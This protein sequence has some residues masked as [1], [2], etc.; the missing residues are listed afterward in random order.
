MNVEIADVIRLRELNHLLEE[1]VI[2]RTRLLM[3]AKQTW[4]ATFDAF[5]DP[6]A[7]VDQ[8]LRIV[9]T[10]L[11]HAKQ[12]GADVRKVNG[13]PCH[14]VLFD[15]T[16]PCESCPAVQTFATGETASGEVLDVASERVFRMWSFPMP[17][18]ESR[19]AV[20]HYKD[21]TEERELQHKLL[22]SEKMAAVGTLAGGVAHEINNPLGAIL[23]FSQLGLREAKAGSVLH[24]FLTEIEDSAQRCKRI[25]SSLLDFSRPSRGERKPV[26]LRPVVEQA[27]FL[28]RTQFR[29][30]RVTIE[31]AFASGPDPV[32]LGDRNQ[33]QQVLLNLMSNAYHAMEETGGQ[34]LVR[35]AVEEGHAV[36]L[37]VEDDGQGIEKR[38]VEKIFEP[39][40]TTK[41]E[42]K[43][44]GLGLAITY[45]IIRDH[46]GTIRVDSA[47]GEGTRFTLRFPWPGEEVQD[48]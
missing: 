3:R 30:S 33:L 45:S 24:D 21:V 28:C 32:V 7:I 23:A 48:G 38:Y 8:K 13:R 11:A 27:V 46:G 18:V 37:T 25:V 19:Q 40:F 10:N 2:E 22:Q 36:H 31:T 1:K 20:C 17:E 42:G 14:Q 9:R 16:T 6:L 44:T 43:G 26:D 34:I 12:A 15:R 29:Q 47:V 4:E 5:V 41:A 39:F 35:S